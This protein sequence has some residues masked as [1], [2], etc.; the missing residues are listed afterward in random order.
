MLGA[1]CTLLDPSSLRVRHCRMAFGGM[2]PTTILALDAMQ[3]A[4]GK[5]VAEALNEKNLVSWRQEASLQALGR[6]AARDC[7]DN[8]RR[9]ARAPAR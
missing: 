9:D 8:A 5:C 7:H 2:A 4:K 6:S 1:F 3:D